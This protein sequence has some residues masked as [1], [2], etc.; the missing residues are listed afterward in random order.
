M[1]KKRGPFAP[2]RMGATALVQ[3]WSIFQFFPISQA[4]PAFRPTAQYRL[5][6][7]VRVKGL[8]FRISGF[9]SVGYLSS[10]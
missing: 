3:R 2:I 6:G 7:M 8:I 1:G 4:F 9:P 5:S 10:V